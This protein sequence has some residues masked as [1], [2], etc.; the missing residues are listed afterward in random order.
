MKIIADRD[1]LCAAQ[2]R[3]GAYSG[4]SGACYL[5]EAGFGYS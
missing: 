2:Q 3:A 5:H 1:E 4:K